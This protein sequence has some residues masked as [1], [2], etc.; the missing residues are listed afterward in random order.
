MDVV[1][2]IVFVDEFLGNVGQH[3]VDVFWLV[4]WGSEVEVLDVE[5]N[6][7]RALPGENTV[8]DEYIILYYREELY[9][10]E[11]GPSQN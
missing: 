2:E 3:D 5:G 11:I 7:L 9:G 1:Q 4:E 10:Q 6:K 8:E